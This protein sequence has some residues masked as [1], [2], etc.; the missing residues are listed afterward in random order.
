MKKLFIIVKKLQRFLLGADYRGGQT[1]VFVQEE[2]I[3][4]NTT[5]E[6]KSDSVGTLA[7]DI[8]ALL[9][10]QQIYKSPKLDLKALSGQ[11]KTPAY[12][13]TRAINERLGVNF[14]DLINR[15]R[16]EEVKL[17]MKGDECKKFTL[18]SLAF[19]AGFSSKTTFNTVFKKFTG[20]TP[21]SYRDQHCFALECDQRHAYSRSSRGIRVSS[22]VSYT[23]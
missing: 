22:G 18:L 19:D 23:N 9:E 16:V 10:E 7:N 5:P 2:G 4:E 17:L 13:V 21:S 6:A 14:N 12:L 11:L 1:T 8:I 3:E 20:Y 15:Y